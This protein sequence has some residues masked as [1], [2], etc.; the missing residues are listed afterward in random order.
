MR[1]ELKYEW[2]DEVSDEHGDIVDCDFS[3][4]LK[5]LG[6][7]KGSLVLVRSAGNEVVGVSDRQWAYVKDGKLPTY[8]SDSAVET[9]VMV[10]KRFHDELANKKSDQNANY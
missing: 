6:D 4:T 1:T 2:G 10:P 5:E 8:F 9:N 3:D 7:I